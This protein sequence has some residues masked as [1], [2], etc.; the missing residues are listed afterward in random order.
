MDHLSNRLL[1][2]YA[3][4]DVTDETELAACEDHLVG[5]EMCRRKAVA[6]DLIGTVPPDSDDKPSLHIAAAYGEG[7]ALCGDEGS[8]NI[9]SEALLRGIDAGVIC[10]ECLAVLRTGA[11]QSVN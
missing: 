1:A 9:I 10:P 2:R 4:G 8:R 11:K 3:L 6:I 5:C 7:K